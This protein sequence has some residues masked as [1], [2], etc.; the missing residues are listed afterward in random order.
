MKT[1]IIWQE[2]ALMIFTLFSSAVVSGIDLNCTGDNC[3]Q[4]AVAKGTINISNVELQIAINKGIVNLYG[5]EN[6]Y[7]VI[8]NYEDKIANLQSQIQSYLTQYQILESRRINDRE[9]LLRAVDYSQILSGEIDKLKTRLALVGDRS[10]IVNDIDDA[11]NNF[12]ISKAKTLLKQ[13]K[14]LD[15][16][17]AGA[18]A[19]QLAALQEADLELNDA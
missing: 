9:A 10:E 6:E 14:M 4:I 7:R 5:G 1:K 11:L 12:N 17:Q 8:S 18:T 15:K 3:T 16:K 2:L 13:K 19:F